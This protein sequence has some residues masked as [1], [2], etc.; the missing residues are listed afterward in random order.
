MEQRKPTNKRVLFTV[1]SPPQTRIL[2][3]SILRKTCS[4]IKHFKVTNIVRFCFRLCISI[5]YLYLFLCRNSYLGVGPHL[6]GQTL[7]MDSTAFGSLI[8]AQV[9]E[10]IFEMMGPGNCWNMSHKWQGGLKDW[11]SF[12][13]I[14]RNCTTSQ[15]NVLGAKN[16]FWLAI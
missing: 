16:F 14:C 13:D 2:Y 10:V 11:S 4:P 12:Q 15:R 7:D 1:P 6:R 3:F 9:P 8:S 5:H